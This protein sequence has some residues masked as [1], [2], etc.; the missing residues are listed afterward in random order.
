MNNISKEDRERIEGQF[1]KFCLTVIE[2][3]A[4]NIHRELNSRNE[5]F[6]SFD[7]LTLSEMNQL[8]TTDT[9]FMDEQ[10]FTICAKPDETIKVVVVNSDLYSAMK[11]LPKN[12]L[13]IILHSY[14]LNKTDREI[15][16]EHALVQSTVCRRRQKILQLLKELIAEEEYK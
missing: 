11:R 8:S 5:K 7:D 4:L 10:T 2:H 1:I 12:K 15:A 3:E 13:D 9:Y 14:F 16:E 6:K